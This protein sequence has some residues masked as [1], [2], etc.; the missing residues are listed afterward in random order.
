MEFYLV[1]LDNEELY[2]E[3]HEVWVLGMYTTLDNALAAAADAISGQGYS[4]EICII[5]ADQEYKR[6]LVASVE[7][8]G[9]TKFPG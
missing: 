9:W 5:R 3:D 7:I 4:A 8:G 1:E 2:P 6:D